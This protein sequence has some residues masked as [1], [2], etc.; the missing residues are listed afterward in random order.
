MYFRRYYSVLSY[1]H[2]RTYEVR[3]AVGRVLG[4]YSLPYSV[5]I[6]RTYTAYELRGRLARLS[7]STF[8]YLSVCLRVA[9]HS[10][11]LLSTRRPT[12]S[13]NSGNKGCPRSRCPISFYQARLRFIRAMDA[14]I[15]A[16]THSIRQ[17]PPCA[18]ARDAHHDT[19]DW[20]LGVRG[21]RGSEAGV[22]GGRLEDQTTGPG[23]RSGVGE[24]CLALFE[25]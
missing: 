6:T 5:R 20:Q 25:I 9:V 3:S 24:E 15:P 11:S 19:L 2:I 4:M 13:S 12:A 21:T 10:I 17:P 14:C 16:H 1:V 7:A 23:T 18:R 22:H 8:V